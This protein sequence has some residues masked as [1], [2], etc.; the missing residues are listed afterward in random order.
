MGLA[1]SREEIQNVRWMLVQN[2]P[3]AM[4]ARI[5]IRCSTEFLQPTQARVCGRGSSAFR[6]AEVSRHF[7]LRADYGLYEYTAYVYR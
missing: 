4:T 3:A 2:V 7:T 5:A 6:K 1:R